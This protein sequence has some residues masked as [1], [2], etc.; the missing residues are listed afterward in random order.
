MPPCSFEQFGLI[1]LVSLKCQEVL[2]L[3]YY[4]CF[5]TSPGLVIWMNL[6]L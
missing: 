5:D 3:L 4:M 1:E 6:R 2:L